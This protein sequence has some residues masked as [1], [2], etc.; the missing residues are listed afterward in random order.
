MKIRA[1]ARSLRLLADWLDTLPDQNLDELKI[2]PRQ[3]H[4]RGEAL[5]LNVATLAGLSRVERSAWIAFIS[6]HKFPI[7]I[8]A[9]DASRDILGKLL[10]FLESR[11]DAVEYLQ[12]KGGSGEVG[13]SDLSRALKAL[14]NYPG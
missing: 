6:E 3:D 2:A 11:P 8:R 1:L 13:S 12:R 10:R 7:E 14:L 9:R 5:A 4:P